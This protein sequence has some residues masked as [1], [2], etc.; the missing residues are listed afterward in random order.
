MGL[1]ISSSVTI[2]PQDLIIAEYISL[3]WISYITYNYFHSAYMHHL[4]SEKGKARRN[5]RDQ[6]KF[7]FPLV[8]KE[9]TKKIV[10]A[11]GDVTMLRNMQ[12]NGEVTS[13]DIVSVFA[14]R[15][16]TIGRKFNLV[17]EEYY[18][19]ALDEARVKDLHLARAIKEKKVQELGPL[20]GIP[21]SIKD[22]V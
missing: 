11:C 3:L 6:K 14:Q 22:H 2:T 10:D 9:K 4:T 13:V 1:Q 18:Y 12:I 20:H 15:C 7:T 5:L 21:I 17:T 8:T 19:E 16:H